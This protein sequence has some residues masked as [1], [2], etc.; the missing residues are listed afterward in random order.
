MKHVLL[1]LVLASVPA[2]A[3]DAQV[4]LDYTKRTRHGTLRFS[5]GGSHYSGYG[6][7]YGYGSFGPGFVGNVGGGTLTFGVRHQFPATHAYPGYGGYGF[8]YGTPG[9]SHSY[10]SGPVYPG[11]YGYA[12]SYRGYGRSF[13]TMSRNSAE[14]VPYPH[15]S[16]PRGPSRPASGSVGPTRDFTAVK[17]ISEGRKLFKIGNYNGALDKFRSAVIAHTENGPV[18]V[19]FGIALAVT[20]DFINADK[21]LRLVAQH[22]PLPKV[23]LSGL[24]KHERERDKIMKRLSKGKN[25][26]TLSL[27]YL[28]YLI[29]NDQ[30]LKKLAEKDDAARNLMKPE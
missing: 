14:T 7:G 21:A 20:G 3:A 19:H 16:A 17:E 9:N 22:S 13:G 1:T 18:Q 27:A 29:G 30:A 26:G 11:V 24:F 10:Y 8:S 15:P 5:I 23:D 12:S 28:Q 4:Q 6:F 25:P 2:A